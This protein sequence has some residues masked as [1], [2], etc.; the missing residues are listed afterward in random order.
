[1][2]IKIGDIVEWSG[3]EYLVVGNQGDDNKHIQLREVTDAGYNVHVNEVVVVESH[4]YGEGH[5]DNDACSSPGSDLY[6]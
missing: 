1:M 3:E 4:S 2:V 5:V 6:L